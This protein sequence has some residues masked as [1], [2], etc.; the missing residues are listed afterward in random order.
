MNTERR[1]ATPLSRREFLPRLAA[2]ALASPAV[3]WRS[4]AAEARSEP[5]A[6][7][8][9]AVIG[10]TGRGN[11]GHEL[12]RAF[13]GCAAVQVV[14]VADPVERG[15][16]AAARRSGALRQYAD[17]RE[18]L[19]KEQPDL[20]V[21][22]P[23]WTEE[24]HAMGLAALQAGAHVLME[25]PITPTLVEA[26]DLLAEAD[27]R[28]LRIAVAHQMRLSPSITYLRQRLA[29]GLIG[30]LAQIRAWG[31]QDRRAGGEDLLVLGTHIFD[32]MRLLAGDPLWCTAR[33]LHR[34]RDLR[35]DD[36]HEATEAIGLVG[37]D[38]IDAQFAFADGVMAFFTS[39]GDLR[40][41]TAHW[42]LELIGS[43]GVVRLLLDIDPTV[44]VLRPGR[45]MPHGKADRWE[46]LAG[47]P[48]LDA[49]PSQRG[50][51]AANR[52]VVADWLDAIRAHREPACS[53][54]DA[55]K[56]LEMIMAVYHAALSGGRVA[57][58]LSERRHPLRSAGPAGDRGPL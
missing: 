15:R 37:G 51:G 30:Q 34:G 13:D 48:A 49:P 50:F 39:R 3:C 29:D 19:A 10:H 40:E 24:H 44:Y 18:M 55:M 7:F 47:D 46:R 8:R 42:G 25:K 22:A 20:V 5:K 45:W 27:R 16:A 41:T 54:R 9:A 56:A 14:A 1:P 2:L 57:F 26:D 4:R 6:T 11:Y 38:H 32:L 17:F 52:R 33:V 43:Q 53:G 35:A 23:R 58:P 12:D 21:V 31:K 36:G 28:R